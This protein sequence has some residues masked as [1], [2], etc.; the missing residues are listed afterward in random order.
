[1]RKLFIPN[2]GNDFKPLLL[3]KSAL[4]VYTVLLLFVNTFGGLV[5]IPKVMASS[6]TPSNIIELTNRERQAYGLNT[7]NTNGL[8]AAAAQAKANNMF[9]EQYWDHFGP[10][11]ETPWKFITEAGYSYVYAGENLAKGFKTA[12]GVHDAWMASPTHKAN[13]VSPTYQ[14][15]GVAVVSGTL[16]GKETVL[17]VQMF[18]NLTDHVYSPAVPAKP[19][20][21]SK[22]K[23]TITTP[24]K[25][26]IKSIMITSPKAADLLNDANVNVKG[27]TVNVGGEYTV[28]ILEGDAILGNTVSSSSA[29]EYD[30]VVDWQEGTHSISAQVKGENTKTDNL[31][32]TI[33]STPPQVDKESIT[34][35]HT[36]LGYE[37]SFAVS[38]DTQTINLVTGDKTY[39]IELVE[40]ANSKLTL[41][42]DSVGERTILMLSDKAGNTSELDISEY[43]LDEETKGVGT[44]ILNLV[45]SNIGTTNGIS[46]VIISFVFLLLSVEVYMYWKKGRLGKHAGELFTLGA[47]CLIIMV[48]LFNGFGGLIS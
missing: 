42:K 6:I 37:L 5:G 21:E 27:E 20:V 43:F 3:R 1:M 44:S 4:V 8:L 23:T 31:V 24:Q 33:D 34:V 39:V 12:E 25:G 38:G 45:V 17:V 7:L 14:D 48:G 46:M 18:G 35:V 30:K 47:W 2:R 19:K 41:S 13:L 9:T 29:W 32:F 36:T 26:E 15:I 10:N 11:G 28:E 16:L 22:P 40:G